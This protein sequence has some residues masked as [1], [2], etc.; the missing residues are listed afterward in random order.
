MVPGQLRFATNPTS[1]GD[2]CR[3]KRVVVALLRWSH[4]VHLGCISPTIVAMTTPSPA[5]V[6]GLQRIC[7]AAGAVVAVDLRSLSGARSN[8]TQRGQ[9]I[10]SCLNPWASAV[11]LPDTAGAD[12]WLEVEAIPRS[13][14]IIRAVAPDRSDS[15]CAGAD[16]VLYP[17]RSGDGPPGASEDR[18]GLCPV[19]AELSTETI[20][21][22]A[23]GDI[24]DVDL[25]MVTDTGTASVAWNRI[26]EQLPMPWILAPG[27]NAFPESVARCRQAV[28]AGASGVSIGPELW[29]D[30]F[31]DDRHDHVPDASAQELRA[32]LVTLQGAI[33]SAMGTW[34]IDDSPSSDATVWFGARSFIYHRDIDRYEERIVLIRA[35][36]AQDALTGSS[37]EADEYAT[38]HGAIA[39]DLVQISPIRLDPTM[40]GG[41]FVDWQE[42]YSQFHS[43][44]SADEFLGRFMSGA[45]RDH[46]RG[47]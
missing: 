13:V 21:D 14:G 23:S 45:Q 11:L 32:R 16:A 5:Q 33:R 15:G 42:V 10:L 19:I 26:D 9:H 17:P 27:S 4:P 20:L 12:R 37:A 6:R 25:V 40:P 39:L 41:D 7:T 28:S 2:R 31:A 29:A 1:I 35:P 18:V 24:C 43:A 47:D 36:N 38:A 8:D 46:R 22:A 34:D 3:P 44:R 30:L